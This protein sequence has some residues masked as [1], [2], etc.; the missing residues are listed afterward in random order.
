MIRIVLDANQF[1]SAL[2]KPA[3][4]PSKI[5]SLIE[6]DRIRL[7]MSEAIITEIDAVLRYPKIVQRHGKSSEYL[8]LFIKRLRSISMMTEGNLR[9]DAI[10]NDPADNRYLECAVE[11][12]ADFIVSGDHHL[13]DLQSFQRIPIVT[14]QFF[15]E[16]VSFLL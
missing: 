13:T 4:N 15:M 7:L 10:Q 2:L 8:D 3:S 5:L 12:K 6:T 1:V 16:Q 11:G 14:P 9:V